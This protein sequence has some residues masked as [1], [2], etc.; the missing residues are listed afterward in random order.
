[1]QRPY[2]TKSGSICLV[3]DKLSKHSRGPF[4]GT[5]LKHKDFGLF[6]LKMVDIQKLFL[7]FLKKIKGCQH[8]ASLLLRLD[9]VRRPSGIGLSSSI[10]EDF[11][12]LR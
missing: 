1:M 3:S 5:Y 11:D 9:R 8:I 12:L 2:S 10:R 7:K 4:L 6:K